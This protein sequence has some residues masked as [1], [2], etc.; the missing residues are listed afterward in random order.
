MTQQIVLLLCVLPL[1]EVQTFGVQPNTRRG[2]IVEHLSGILN[3][4][5]QTAIYY[6]VASTFLI[7]AFRLDYMHTY[8]VFYKI[9]LSKYYWLLLF[10]TYL[11]IDISTGLYRVNTY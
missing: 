9:L 3:L 1:R 10:C 8:Y 5:N 11:T 2:C 7:W 4:K 6:I